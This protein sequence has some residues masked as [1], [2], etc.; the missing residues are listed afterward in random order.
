MHP[1]VLYDTHMHTPLCKHA[2]GEPED[3]AAVAERRGLKGIVVT[4]HNP[5]P[6]GYCAESRMG[7]DQ[8]GEYLRIVN[9]A[10]E[11]WRDRVD[12]RLRLEQGGAGSQPPPGHTRADGQA[13]HPR[14]DRFRFTCSP[15]RWRPV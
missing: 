7:V 3:Y 8:I 13:R 2:A 9:R 11:S 15:A 5:M 12:V 14:R 10:M 6:D 4:C 1:P